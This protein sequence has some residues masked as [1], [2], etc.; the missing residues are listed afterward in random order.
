MLLGFFLSY[1]L[2]GYY[3]GLTLPILICT[4]AGVGFASGFITLLLKP[5]AL[6]LLAV[7]SGEL[8]AYVHLLLM[9][10]LWKTQSSLVVYAILIG[11]PVLVGTISIIPFFYK[12][13]I[14]FNT[15]MIGGGLVM[16]FLDIY[17]NKIY[18][19]YY[20]HS[21]LKAVSLKE[22]PEICAVSWALFAAWPLVTLSGIAL[23]AT[24]T[25][26]SVNHHIG[27]HLTTVYR[28]TIFI[29]D[30]SSFP[31][32][33]FYDT[34][35]AYRGNI[36]ES[37]KRSLRI[38]SYFLLFCFAY[39]KNLIMLHDRSCQ[40]YFKTRYGGDLINFGQLFAHQ[41]LLYLFVDCFFY[42]QCGFRHG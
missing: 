25:A 19:T 28:L 6:V 16:S 37:Q 17:L 34:S 9:A 7:L 39:Q 24:F 13:M 30:C 14:I 32:F 4:A 15:S 35:S 29:E 20:L 42:N 8:S 18:F 38:L 21:I 3:S 36:F 12:P 2:L 5:V 40:F 31:H 26:R 22:T 23:Q 11:W 27:K 10:Q 1:T 41:K 33:S